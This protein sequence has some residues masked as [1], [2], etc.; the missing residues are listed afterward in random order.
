MSLTCPPPDL[1]IKTV[2]NNYKTIYQID[3][4]EMQVSVMPADELKMMT[5]GL[6]KIKNDEN[7]TLWD[8]EEYQVLALKA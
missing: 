8:C 3:K 4:Y 7:I 6:E 1:N 2:M 5:R